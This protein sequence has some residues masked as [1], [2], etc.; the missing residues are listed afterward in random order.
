MKITNNGIAVLE[1]D[2]HISRWVEETGLIDHGQQIE[3]TFRKWIKP[4]DTV[5]DVGGLIGDH[6]VPYAQIVGPEG[7]VLAFEPN[8]PAFECLKHNTSPYPWVDIY[9]MGLSDHQDVLFIVPN[10]NVGA[11]HL[12]D[13]GEGETI[14]VETLDSFRLDRLDFIKI[15]VEG[16]EIDVLDG[17]LETINRCRPIILVEVAIHQERYGRSQN[18]LFA[19]IESHLTDY[20]MHPKTHTGEPQY[21]LVATPK[22]KI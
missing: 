21:D 20:A 11:S 22:E 19:W 12:T 10:E 16:M 4:G 3:K 8:P 5:V 6:T 7:L 13:R 9:D 1:Q 17:A 18:H 2:T 14:A 15:D